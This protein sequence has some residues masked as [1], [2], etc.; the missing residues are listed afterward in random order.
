MN[1]IIVGFALRLGFLIAERHD[2]VP[3]SGASSGC[4]IVVGGT[5]A[6][7]GHALIADLRGLAGARCVSGASAPYAKGRCSGRG[8]AMAGVMVEAQASE[9]LDH[10][11]HFAESAAGPANLDRATVCVEGSKL[12]WEPR[13]AE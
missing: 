9:T 12:G 10:L 13:D 2:P 11:D 3:E 1:L 7:G 6:V 8:A 5:V 4:C